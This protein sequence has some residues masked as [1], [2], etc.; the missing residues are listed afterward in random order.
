MPDDTST[1]TG[2]VGARIQEI[3]TLRDLTLRELAARC[4]VSPSMLSRIE[5]GSRVPSEQV[6][7]AVARALS[8]TVTVLH[9][10]PYIEQL[11]RDQLDRLIAPLSNALDDWGIPPEDDDPAPRSL[12][13]LQDVVNHVR[14]LRT[15]S[16][17]ADLAELTPALLSELSHATQLYTV[18]GRDREL[19]HWLQAEAALGAFSVA[20]KFGYMDLARLAL[21]RMA[22]AAAQSGDPRQVAAERLKRAQLSTEGP[23]MERGLRL[24]AQALRDLDDD[25]TPQTR[26]MRGGLLL[27]G[28]QLSALLG[29][30]DGSQAHLGEAEGM[31]REIGETNHYMLVFGPTNVAQHAVAAAGDRDEHA[32]ALSIAKEIRVPVNYPAARHGQLLIDKARSQ[33]LSARLDDALGSLEKAREVSPLQTRYHPS[34]RQT[35]GVL[36]RARPRASSHLLAFARWSGV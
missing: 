28:G 17:Y 27:K 19:A 11:R 35:V 24:V 15:D 10:Q 14:R 8:V 18:A 23:S 7:A 34:T 4:H 1:R 30:K 6:V 3:R 2:G 31:A 12:P 22:M 16:E 33:A 13:E 5:S 25:G 20:Y 29:D 26:A 21:C 32:E 9:G 36:L